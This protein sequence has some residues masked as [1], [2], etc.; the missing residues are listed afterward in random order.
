MIGND[1][2][3]QLVLTANDQASAI[4]EKVRKQIQATGAASGQ[5]GKKTHELNDEIGKISDGKLV[6]SARAMSS[7]AYAAEEAKLGGR[8][9][10]R[11]MG[12]LA[13]T[14]ALASGNAKFAGWAIGLN[15]AVLGATA[16]IG[17][18]RD[19]PEQTKPT[20]LFIRRLSHLTKDEADTERDQ[21]RNFRDS[22]L[23]QTATEA[24]QYWTRFK[25]MMGANLGSDTGR[26][27]A[28]Q[29]GV[30]FELLDHTNANLEELTRKSLIDLTTAERNRVLGLKDQTT[31]MSKQ[32]GIELELGI[33]KIAS[34]HH[35]MSS[36]ELQKQEALAGKRNADQQ[37]DTMFRFRDANGKIHTLTSAELA[38]K[39]QLLERNR[40][41]YGQA[42]ATARA[43]YDELVSEGRFQ[44]QQIVWYARRRLSQNDF[45]NSLDDARRSYE[46]QIHALERSGL[47]AS[48]MK[49]KQDRITEAYTLQVQLL[50]QQ[51]DIQTRRQRAQNDVD[52]AGTR[53]IG[54]G[55]VGEELR[56]KLEAIETARVAA[57]KAGEDEVEANRTA[58]IA[59]RK[60]LRDTIDQA[61]QNYKTMEDVLLASNSRQVKAVGHAVQTIR[62]LE[63]GVEGSKAAVMALREGAEAL[64][65]F[66]HGD[67]AG[68]GLHLA[69][70]A[71]FAATA[72]LAAQE[73]LGG[74]RSVSGGGGGGTTGT[75][76]FEPRNNGGGGSQSIILITKDPYGREQMQRVMWELDRAGQM[77]RPPVEIPPTSGIGGTN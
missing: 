41:I 28:R 3:L 31:E 65:S 6:K 62:R 77:K 70:A 66:A 4:L 37:T 16:L 11:A 49:A 23:Q 40:Q 53:L 60:L 58:E 67:F 56:A 24:D 48:D 68:G 75:S 71:Q 52:S 21:L 73:S 14:L 55:N 47:E 57:I 29:G 27:I 43:T 59:K 32:K 7:I 9:A 22:I 19:A 44:D 72:A 46:A 5:G 39:G 51:H 30:D 38:L 18:L 76:T 25:K 34:I 36:I 50:Q 74:G 45:Q 13:E 15:A 64:A 12:E 69:S 54:P 2:T 20:D 17:V 10:A 26:R 42:V 33:A 61:K 63:I 1:A 8:E 35:Q